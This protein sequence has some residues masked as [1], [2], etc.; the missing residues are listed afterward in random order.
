MELYQEPEKDS[1]GIQ[2][3]K[4]NGKVITDNKKAEVL[5]SHFRS[6]F[7]VEPNELPPEKESSP[8]APMA[9][10]NITTPGSYIQFTE[11]PEY[12]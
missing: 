3:L 2:S 12:L 6:I 5:D 7:T 4:V 10:I 1:C 9:N 8:H 11:I